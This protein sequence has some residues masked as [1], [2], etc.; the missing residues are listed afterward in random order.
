[1]TL[2][3][4]VIPTNID[5]C[6]CVSILCVYVCTN[7]E[8]CVCVLCCVCVDVRIYERFVR[9]AELCWSRCMSRLSQNRK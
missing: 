9:H 7:S 1:M 5:A 6:V 8:V 3:N 4:P 2:E